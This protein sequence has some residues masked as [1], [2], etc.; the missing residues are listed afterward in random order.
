[1]GDGDGDRAGAWM[2]AG[3]RITLG[4]I[5]EIWEASLRS[6]AER[7]L[8]VYS[9]SC[10]SG[11]LCAEASRLGARFFVQASCEV[12]E[13]SADGEFTVLF[14]K[15]Q[16]RPQDRTSLVADFAAQNQQTPTYYVPAAGASGRGAMQKQGGAGRTS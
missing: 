16:Q 8:L 15:A 9:D 1:M 10:F 5:N 13:E 7:R 11:G 6:D 14:V 12:Q 4:D 3:G 2:F